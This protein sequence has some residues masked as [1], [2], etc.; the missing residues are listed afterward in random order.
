MKA[1]TIIILIGLISISMASHG[2]PKHSESESDE[3]LLIQLNSEE[4]SGDIEQ[5]TDIPPKRNNGGEGKRRRQQRN[6]G[7]FIVHNFY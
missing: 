2:S 4:G 3:N 6:H 5:S 7:Q 1:T